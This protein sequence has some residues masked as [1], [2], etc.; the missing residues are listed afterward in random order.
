MSWGFV[1]LPP[2]EIPETALL[3]VKTPLLPV[4]IHETPPV[5]HKHATPCKTCY[6]QHPPMPMDAVELL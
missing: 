2:Y 4:K 5:I 1:N 6:L 3:P